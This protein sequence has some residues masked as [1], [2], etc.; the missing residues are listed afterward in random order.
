M[1]P[2][3]SWHQALAAA[4][5]ARFAVLLSPPP[6]ALRPPALPAVLPSLPAED[7]NGSD[8]GSDDGKLRLTTGESSFP[9]LPVALGAV[10]FFLCLVC[11]FAGLLWRRAHTRKAAGQKRSGASRPVP[12]IKIEQLQATRAAGRNHRRLPFGLGVV[13]SRSKEEVVAEARLLDGGARGQRGGRRIHAP[14]ERA[15]LRHRV[16]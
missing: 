6:P 5:D 15:R 10:G 8:D 7:G 11:I 16:G 4:P 13:R 1:G 14:R 3:P 9:L 2:L 12:Q